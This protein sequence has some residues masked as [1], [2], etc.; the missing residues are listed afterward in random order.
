MS[1]TGARLGIELV[2]DN[3]SVR[4]GRIVMAVNYWASRVVHFCA[5]VV[6]CLF[7]LV[8]HLLWVPSGT[9]SSSRE[10]TIHD[11]LG[12]CSTQKGRVTF[13]TAGPMNAA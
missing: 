5:D 7:A 3:R 9:L 10:R 12:P 13:S 1:A 4:A 11:V 6:L 8:P 2:D